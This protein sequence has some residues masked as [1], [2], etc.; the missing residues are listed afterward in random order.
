MSYGDIFMENQKE[1]LKDF[2]DFKD[3]FKANVTMK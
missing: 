3:A 1:T 2:S